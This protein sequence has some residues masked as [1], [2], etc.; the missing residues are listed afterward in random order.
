MPTAADGYAAGAPARLAAPGG[1]CR[2]EA[3]ETLTE[4]ASVK[5]RLFAGFPGGSRSV[6]RLFLRQ[7][8]T[9]SAGLDAGA[10]R[11]RILHQ[12]AHAGEPDQPRD[13]RRVP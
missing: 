5:S 4:G 6:R 10:D 2:C 7:V 3:A 11:L 13:S 1:G 12:G 8:A 9:A